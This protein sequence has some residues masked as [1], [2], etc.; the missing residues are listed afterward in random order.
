MHR[1]GAAL[2]LFSPFLCQSL[3]FIECFVVLFE[4]VELVSIP[5]RALYWDAETFVGC[6]ILLFANDTYEFAHGFDAHTGM[7]FF[8][9]DWCC[10]AE[11][12]RVG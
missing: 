1:L 2:V 6:V 7:D 11:P 4:L 5:S 12:C 9:V 8:S 10:H 3:L